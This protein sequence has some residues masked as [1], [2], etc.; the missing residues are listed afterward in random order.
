VRGD[1]KPIKQQLLSDT[2]SPPYLWRAVAVHVRQ[3]NHQHIQ[4]RSADN[5]AVNEGRQEICPVCA[6]DC[7]MQCRALLPAVAA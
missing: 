4:R 1:G 2:A 6:P 3:A 5:S 7:H